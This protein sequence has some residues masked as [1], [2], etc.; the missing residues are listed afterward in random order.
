MNIF[1]WLFG[2]KTPDVPS[3][4]RN[5]NG[6]FMKLASTYRITVFKSDQS[7]KEYWKFCYSIIEESGF[8]EDDPFY[9]DHYFSEL[10]ARDE[11]DAF[12]A[13]QPLTKPTL[14][15]EKSKKIRDQLD[16]RLD[17]Q[18]VKFQEL[19]AKIERARSAKTLTIKRIENLKKEANSRI[20][21]ANNL[22]IQAIEHGTPSQDRRAGA[23]DKKHKTLWPMIDSLPTPAP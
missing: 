13:G 16:Q 2:S 11:A 17:Q 9:S 18:E 22:A 14:Q 8:D 10:D 21:Q 1:K 19:V 12:E 3:W 7:G 4:T 20:L 5:A 23:L 15:A 6:N